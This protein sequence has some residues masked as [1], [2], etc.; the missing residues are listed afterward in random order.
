[1]TRPLN[2]LLL[3]V[4]FMPLLA[5]GA[6]WHVDDSV[7]E[8]GDG[9]SWETAFK[10]IQEGIDAASAG[11]TVVVAEGTYLENINFN[12]KNIVLTSTDPLDPDVVGNTIID[13][14]QIGPVVIFQGTEDETCRLSGFTI[15]GGFADEG[16]GICG[17]GLYLHNN[18]L[19]AYNIFRDNRALERGGG[20]A[21]CDGRLWLNTLSGNFTDGQGGAAYGCN[22]EL[23]GNFIS[24]NCAQEGGGL[25]NCQATITRN[26]LSD[27]KASQ[28]YGGLYLCDPTISDNQITGSIGG[29]LAHCD[30]S[31]VRNTISLTDSQ[32]VLEDCNGLIE[33]N[34]IT[35]NHGTALYD[36][37]GTIRNNLISHNGGKSGGGLGYC[38]GLILN[39]TIIENWS[40][41]GGGLSSCLGV[42]LNCTIWGNRAYYDGT[43][44]LFFSSEP[45][46]SCIQDWGGGEGNISED[47][48]FVDPDGPDDN[49][50]TW[51]DN[52]YRLR[53]DSPCIDVGFNS[54]DLPEF[55]IAGMPRIMYGGRSLTVDI[56][57]YEFFYSGVQTGP[58][59]H[60]ATL[61]WSFVPDKTYSI[62]YTDDLLNWHIAIDNFPSLG[63]HTTSWTDDGSLTG[64]PPLLAPRRFYRLLEN[65]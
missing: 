30:G 46:Y 50:E 28:R 39:N 36:C 17:G 9:T 63:N 18:A 56:G 54:L 16:A 12:G 32:A 6:A 60:D 40:G 61:V 57:A 31:I 15:Q 38:D 52:D 25:A 59:P 65:P 20:V 24:E 14:A 34:R 27:N 8:S 29:A 26:I 45:T 58:G 11:D 7:A 48:K 47:P 35:G 49:P 37:D 21:F 2:L 33:G 23:V 62:F 22:G 4:L 53:G 44:Q 13:G 55:D 10:T 43:A 19:I 51:E 41:A 3:P 1:M 5:S 42:I 64:I